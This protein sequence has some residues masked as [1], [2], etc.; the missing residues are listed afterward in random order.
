MLKTIPSQES[1]LETPKTFE[2]LASLR[3]SIVM[4]IAQHEA[5]DARTKFSIQKAL[6]AAENVFADRAILLDE[7]LLL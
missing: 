4:N 2:N 6:N 7:N 1:Q 3:K 5:I